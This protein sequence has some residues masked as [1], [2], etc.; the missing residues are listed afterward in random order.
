MDSDD[1]IQRAN[2]A[3]RG[4]PFLN[5]DQAAAYLM[6][7]SRLLKRLRKNGTGPLFRRHSRFVQYHIDDLNAWSVGNSVR[8][9]GHD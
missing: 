9:N 7:S 5:T 6:M 8:G 3:K 2:R 1:D 4:S